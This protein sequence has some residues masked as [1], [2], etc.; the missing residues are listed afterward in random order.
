MNTTIL[1]GFVRLT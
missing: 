1:S